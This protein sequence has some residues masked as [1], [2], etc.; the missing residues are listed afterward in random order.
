[1]STPLHSQIAAKIAQ[2]LGEISVAGGFNYTPTKAIATYGIDAW[3]FN[4]S[5]DL[6]YALLPDTEDATEDT[7]LFVTKVARFDIIGVKLYSPATE[8]LLTIAAGIAVPEQRL[9]V[10]DKMLQ[11][12]ER[13]LRPNYTLDGLVENLDIVAI[14]RGAGN[15]YMDS[16][17]VV[18]LH[19]LVRYSHPV[20]AP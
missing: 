14:D 12:V 20:D 6:V 10:Q 15:T 5:V 9:A 1:M 11:D 18:F 17:A 16:F 13:K 4:A 3:L 8:D 2:H 19:L 7:S